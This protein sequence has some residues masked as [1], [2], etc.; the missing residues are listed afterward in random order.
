MAEQ[1]KPGNQVQL[2]SGGPVMTISNYDE[3]KKKYTCHWFDDKQQLHEGTFTEA[4]LKLI[5]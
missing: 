4:E 2:Q 5:S 1:L 3:K